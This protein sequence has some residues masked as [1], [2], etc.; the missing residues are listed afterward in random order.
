MRSLAVVFFTIVLFTNFAFG[1]KLVKPFQTHNQSPLVHFFGIPTNLGGSIL[2]K[3]T[4]WFGN[5]FNIANNATSA[6]INEE[7]I[8]L[9]GEMYRNEL[10]LSYG[11][12]SKLDVGVVIPIVKHSSGVMDSFISDWHDAFNL[13]GK[14]RKV[15]PAYSLNYFFMEEEEIVFEMNESKLSF[16]DISVSLGTPIIQNP[17]HDLSFRTFVK[18]PIGNKTN[19]VGSGTSDLGFQITGML[20][21]TPERKEFSFYYSGGYVRIGKGALLENKVTSNVGFG[22]FG[23]AFNAND[24][25]YLKSQLDFHTSL[26]E[27]SYTKQ[28]GKASAQLVLGLDYFVANDLAV[29]IAFVEDIIVNTAPD[30][31]LQVGISYQF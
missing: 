3:N 29:S 21:S 30:F 2:E 17:N 26:Y 9:D 7:A 5:Y 16:G 4:F 18:L 20:N 31:V 10:F 22:S 13:P 23:L 25:W 27:K 6:Q 8:Y 24:N 15:M 12:L 19:L 1:Q 11:L 14:S 28:L